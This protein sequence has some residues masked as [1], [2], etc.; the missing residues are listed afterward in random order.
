MK[1]TQPVTEEVHKTSA[2]VQSNEAQSVPSS[3]AVVK[4]KQTEG[5][6]H[7]SVAGGIGVKDAEVIAERLKAEG[8]TRAKVLNND[9]KIR[10]SIMRCV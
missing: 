2:A 9:G 5:N 6:F 10:V 1:V 8:F 7:I 4:S 3:K